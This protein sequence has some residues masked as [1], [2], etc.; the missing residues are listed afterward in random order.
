MAVIDPLREVILPKLEMVKKVGAGFAARC[1]AHEDRAPSLSLGYG[2]KQPVVM[3]C[4][5]GCDSDDI[6]K[7]IGLE[8]KDLSEPREDRPLD[9][10]SWTPAGPAIAIYDYTDADGKLLY[11][12]CRTAMKDFRQR[13]P[14]P[15]KKSGWSWNLQ[16]VS[17]TIYRLPKVVAAVKDGGEVWIAEGEKDVHALEAAGLVATCNSGGAGKWLPEFSEV[18][19]GAVTVRIV[20]DR[21]DPGRDHARMIFEQ[22]R[23]LVDLVEIYEAPKHKDIAA[24][25]GAG[26]GLHELDQTATTE[27]TSQPELA[28]DLWEFIAAGE[29]SYDWLVDEVLER[30]DRFMLTGHE[31]LGKSVLCRQLGVQFAAGVHPFREGETFQP[32]RV[33][34]V[35][36]ENSPRQNRRHYGDLA[37]LSVAKGRRVPDGGLRLIHRPEGIDLTRETDA[38][39]LLERVR[40]HRPDVMYIGSFYRLHNADVNDEK[41]A[42]TVVSVLDRCRGIGDGVA[43]LMEAH[44]GHGMADGKRMLRPAGASLLM[45]WPEFGFGIRRAKECDPSD[46]RPRLVDL[47]PWRGARDERAWPAGFRH[48][49]PGEWPWMPEV[50]GPKSNLGGLSADSLSRSRKE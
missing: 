42:R 43:L 24:H 33:L 44:A 23:P 5:A 34:V 16:G 8:W 22:L 13:R 47:E 35:D 15:A 27:D 37:G 18:F 26:M 17:R 28:P 48:G 29:D 9:G 31:G 39:W 21:D 36:C 25:L 12:V 19:A 14:D 11:Q 3:N 6:L 40:A 20:A 46:P 30:G 10:D 32:L 49:R 45:R 38:A 2:T 41:A 4:H 1:P 7:A 50:H